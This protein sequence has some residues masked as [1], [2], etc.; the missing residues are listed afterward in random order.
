[1]GC[2]VA[3][4]ITRLATRV[5]N[6]T[7]NGID[8][9]DSA[10]AR[11]FLGAPAPDHFAM[12]MTLQGPRVIAAAGAADI[13]NGIFAHWGEDEAPDADESYRRIV[14]WISGDAN[15][16][17]G[18]ERVARG[19]TGQA[20]GVIRWLGHHGFPL[21]KS[22]AAALPKGARYLNVS[23]FP[24]WI[25]SYFRWL[26][27]RPDVRGVF[28]IHDL[29]PIEAPEYFRKAE[30]E[31]HMRRLANLAEFGAAAIVTTEVVKETLQRH[32]APLGRADMQILVAPIP[33]SPIFSGRAA[34]PEPQF[35]APYFVACGT[36]EPRKNHLLLLHVWREL[37]RRDGAGAPKLV[38]IGAR[39]WENE[40]V[41][42]LLERC[43][44]I[45]P[46]VIEAS[47][48]STPSLKA[49]LEGARALLMP[50]FAEGFG[51]PIAE[52]LACGTPVIASDIA[53]FR[54]S[55]GGCVTLVSPIDGE[56]WL[57]TIRAFAVP[58]SPERATAEARAKR[59]EA[60]NWD[61]YFATVEAFLASL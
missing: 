32:L 13:V 1:M 8:R 38:L 6:R 47:G 33:A 53:A 57:E 17:E 24:L 41:V 31:R 49:L 20:A 52:A 43:R 21:G 56:K 7:P 3:F 36:I 29:L 12:M 19:R 35:G 60:P 51:L 15:T 40:N 26:K 4:D 25:P 50:S 2:P 5:L 34:K 16:F 55:G 58:Q 9:I 42:D 45:R 30:Y 23:Q 54:E 39:G 18:A 37:A 28:F 61:G 22:P 10:F 27:Q 48:L 44:A 14:K 59:F 46:H 11:R